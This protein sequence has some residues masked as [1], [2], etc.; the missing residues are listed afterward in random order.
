[1]R[2]PS[3]SERPA[4]PGICR[5]SPRGGVPRHAPGWGRWTREFPRSV[6]CRSDGEGKLAA[7]LVRGGHGRRRPGLTTATRCE[8]ASDLAAAGFLNWMANSDVGCRGSTILQFR[9]SAVP[10]LWGS[11]DL[12]CFGVARH[13]PAGRRGRA[14][15]HYPVGP[16]RGGR[17]TKLTESAATAGPS[18]SG[19]S[20]RS[21]P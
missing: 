12:R 18:R 14:G 9:S 10:Q 2:C 11:G 6:T 5:C 13:E 20:S 15:M 4:A 1:M 16:V 19:T 17:Q 8:A 7:V 21:P 3:F